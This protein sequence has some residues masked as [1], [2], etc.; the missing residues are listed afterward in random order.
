M[1][2]LNDAGAASYDDADIDVGLAVDG[3]TM[4]SLR[5]E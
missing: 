3:I 2:I 1:R 5:R 4:G